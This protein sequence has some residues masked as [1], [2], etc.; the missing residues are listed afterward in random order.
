ISSEKCNSFLFVPCRAF[1]LNWNHWL[2]DN[3]LCPLTIAHER[4][5]SNFPPIVVLEPI[6]ILL[7][8]DANGCHVVMFAIP[9][10]ALSYAPHPGRHAKT[11]VMH[12]VGVT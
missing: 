7:P 9:P 3:V 6:S 11:D 1:T 4:C 5:L 8:L 2:I 10:V 12:G